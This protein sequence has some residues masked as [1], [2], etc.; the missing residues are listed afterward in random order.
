[1]DT[2]ALFTAGV[3]VGAV[4]LACMFL[5]GL[6]LVLRQR[7]QRYRS[8]PAREE[9]GQAAATGRFQKEVAPLSPNMQRARSAKD[10]EAWERLSPRR[11]EAA[12]LA[13]RGLTNAEIAEQMQVRPGTVDGYLKEV[14]R[15]LGLH[16]RAELVNFVRDIAP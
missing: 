10:A 14:Y 11:K 2:F 4:A 13:A 1:M 16:S 7:T 9:V 3:L 8:A 12:L 6:W 15:S 5:F